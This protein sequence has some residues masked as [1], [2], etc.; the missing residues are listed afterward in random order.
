MDEAL[1]AAGNPMGPLTLADL[2]GN[3]VNLAIMERMYAATKDPVHKPSPLLVRVNRDGLLGRK[4]KAGF[5]RYDGQEDLPLV[6][7]PAVSRAD[8]LPLALLAP[9]LNDACRMVEES[10]A[11]E[12]DINTA[13]RHRCRRCP[14]RSRKGSC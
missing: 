11:T 14:G 7:Q 1:V 2:I 10:Y 3:D 4:T 6:V 5:Y 13:R 12:D 9:Y 8:E